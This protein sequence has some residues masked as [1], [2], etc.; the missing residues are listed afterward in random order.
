MNAVISSLVGLLIL[1]F[2]SEIFE[3]WF[4]GVTRAK[5]GVVGVVIVSV[6]FIP[7]ALI[8]SMIGIVFFSVALNI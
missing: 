1:W 3:A 4:D 6:L 5:F 2:A 8:F 7:V